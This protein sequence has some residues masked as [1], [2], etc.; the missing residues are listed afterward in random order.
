METKELITLQ[1]LFDAIHRYG[2]ECNFQYDFGTAFSSG[3]NFAIE[4]LEVQKLKQEHAEMVEMLGNY[5]SD[6]RNI[7]IESDAR[8]SR[9]YDV[10][11]LLNKIKEN[12]N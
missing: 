12:G 10:K 9:I 11:E 2:N 8:N 5:L 4:K 3:V 6:L 7:I 1:E